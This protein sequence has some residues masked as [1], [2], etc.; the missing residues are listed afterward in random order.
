[1]SNEKV[2]IVDDDESVR[3]VLKKSLEKDGMETALAKNAAEA[4]ERI[5]EGDIAVALMD[6]RMPGMSGFEALEQ[7]Q[8]GGSAVSVI[9]MTAQATMQ[10][11]IEAMRRGAFDY[12]TKPFDLDEVN[13]LVRKA[14][15]VRR[16]SLEVNVLRAEVR[17]KYEGGLVGNTSA[18][19]E[20]YKT[21]GRVAESDATVLIHG[22]SGTGKELVAR[23]I[24]YHSKRAGRPFVAVNSAAI[25]SELLESELFGHEKGSF[26]GAVA[27]KIGKFEAAAGGTL[28]L[29]EIGDMNLPLQGKL[30]RVLQEREF[31]RVGGTE[32]IKTEVRVIAATHRNLEK[33]V[34][35]KRFR[36]DLFYRLNV[37]QI[38]IP[39]LR[40]RKDDIPPLADFFMQKHQT[41]PGKARVLT[42]ETLKVLRAYDWPG[43]VRE[44]EN[45]IQRAITLSPG[46]K[47]FPDA[48]PPQIFKPGHGVGL[49]F[50]NFLEEKLADLVDRMGGL[51]TG[52]IHSLVIQRVEKPLITL[53]L[54]KTEGNQVRAAN[55]LGINRNTLRK[56]IKEL[57]IKGPFGAAEDEGSEEEE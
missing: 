2:L 20:I 31:E 12:I 1:M 48:L 7:I 16:L 15:D 5:G 18:M 8:T 10:N 9:I 43:N 17:E 30:L 33:F 54:K 21:I 45:A 53:V 26:T 40:K 19:Q 29:D 44:L 32:A 37:I 57:G 50:E 22:E 47:I 6:I 4:L 51:E 46:D 28:F 34:R 11:A 24:H 36:E 3:W 25:P 35:E 14:I 13:I 23:A 41:A 49:S 52:D 55:L 27:R 38:N 56:K 39:P 42:P